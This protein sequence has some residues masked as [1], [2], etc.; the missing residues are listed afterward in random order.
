MRVTKFLITI[1]CFLILIANVNAAECSN[2]EKVAL[3]KEAVAVKVNYEEAQEAYKSDEIYPPD[4][5][6]DDENYVAYYNY[7]KINFYNLTEN[8]FIEVTNDKTKETTTIKY[9]DTNDGFYQMKYY[10]INQVS[11]FTYTIYASV[12]TNCNREV[13]K[14]GMISLP[15]FNPYHE[16]SKCKLVEDFALCAKYL[17]VDI[18]YEKFMKEIDKE[19]EKRNKKQ[20]ITE[21]NKV[22][23]TIKNFLEKNKKE[24]I[25]GSIASVVLIGAI[26]V[27]II[28]KHKERAI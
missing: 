13:I 12:K 11:S 25:I 1:L 8:I 5:H 10:Q 27:L 9:E 17:N 21:Q 4:G 7:F 26:V 28:R 2:A 23:N 6:V 22:S 19:I 15:A 3:G 24:I 20:E 16:Y 14:K 18:T